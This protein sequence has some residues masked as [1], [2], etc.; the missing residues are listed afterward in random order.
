M[1]LLTPILYKRETLGALSWTADLNPLY[2]VLSNLRHAL[3]AGEVK[4]IQA[5]SFLLLNLIGIF[6][7]LWLLQRQHRQL[8][9]LV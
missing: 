4:Y 9:F 6:F 7:S 3:I 5:L 8:P 2:R 1:F